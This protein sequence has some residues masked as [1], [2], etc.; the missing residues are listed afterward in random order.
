[1]EGSIEASFGPSRHSQ[2]RCDGR[3][4]IVDIGGQMALCHKLQQLYVIVDYEDGK[5][6]DRREEWRDVPIV[7]PGA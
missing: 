6:V 5:A 3:V 1:M 4:R 2:V 7:A